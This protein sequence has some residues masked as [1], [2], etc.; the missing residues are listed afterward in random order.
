MSCKKLDGHVS[1]GSRALPSAPENAKPTFYMTPGTAG[2]RMSKSV[3][4]SSAGILMMQLAAGTF[5]TSFPL[6]FLDKPRSPYLNNVYWRG[7]QDE[8]R[9]KLKS[10]FDKSEI[11]YIY[12]YISRTQC[13]RQE[14]NLFIS[15]QTSTTHSTHT[16][17]TR[18]YPITTDCPNLHA[19]PSPVYTH[20]AHT[21]PVLCQCHCSCTPQTAPHNDCH[22]Y[23]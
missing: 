3:S 10:L 20:P 17:S 16:I 21:G 11:P 12:I 14:R 9:K 22:Y 6:F 8:S 5:S 23:C 18:P 13:Y 2:I 15:F 4:S 7:S 19:R 1:Q